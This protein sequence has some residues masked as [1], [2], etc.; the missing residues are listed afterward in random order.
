MGWLYSIVLFM[1][2]I[3][4]QVFL[5]CFLF[6]SLL[7][8]DCSLGQLWK[9]LVGT[10]GWEGKVA[11]VPAKHESPQDTGFVYTFIGPILRSSPWRG[12]ITMQTFH[13]PPA[14]QLPT[15]LARGVIFYLALPLLLFGR[16]V[17]P[18]KLPLPVHTPPSSL[19]KERFWLDSSEFG[20]HLCDISFPSRS[21]PLQ[22]PSLPH[23]P[24]L[25]LG[26]LGRARHRLCVARLQPSPGWA[27]N[28]TCFSCSSLLVAN[29]QK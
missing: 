19:V 7:E 5:C 23:A 22:P 27:N 4:S 8:G 16:Q 13:Q 17:G 29:F 11:H 20:T 25:Y 6:E 15:N 28:G 1:M 3:W 2:N 14:P 26:C 10:Q 24:P 18:E 9:R 21:Y 12:L